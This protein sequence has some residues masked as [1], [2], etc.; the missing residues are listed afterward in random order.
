MSLLTW[1]FK[2]L[3]GSQLEKVSKWPISEQNLNPLNQK[4]RNACRYSCWCLKAVVTSSCKSYPFFQ[5]SPQNPYSYPKFS[6]CVKKKCFFSHTLFWLEITYAGLRAESHS[7]SLHLWEG[8][9]GR[10]FHVRSQVLKPF[11]S[12]WCYRGGEVVLARAPG[13]WRSSLTASCCSALWI[14][15]QRFILTVLGNCVAPLA[16]LGWRLW[17]AN[18]AAGVSREPCLPHQIQLKC[19]VFSLFRKRELK[20]PRSLPGD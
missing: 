9:K 17:M 16:V 7:L 18:A 6:P 4:M 15:S 14:P 10:C 8:K 12:L 20:P 1:I 13:I 19:R 5:F 2:R 11:S 3:L